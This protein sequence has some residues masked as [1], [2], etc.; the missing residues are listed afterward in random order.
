MFHTAT[1]LAADFAA[2]ALPAERWHQFSRQFASVSM[3]VRQRRVQADA[4]EMG[5]HLRLLYP[6]DPD[7]REGIRAMIAAAFEERVFF[8]KAARDPKWRPQIRLEGREYLEAAL[9]SGRGAVL[10]VVP[11][12]FATLV[13]KMAL[14]DAGFRTA[15][16]SRVGHGGGRSRL[17]ANLLNERQNVIEER[18][19]ER[20]VMPAEGRPTQ[21]LRELKRRLEANSIVTITGV[22][23]ADN[24]VELPFLGGR[25]RFATGAPRLAALN[26]APL[27]AAAALREGRSHRFRVKLKPLDLPQ[28]EMGRGRDQAGITAQTCA[29]AEVYEETVRHNPPL[30]RRGQSAVRVQASRGPDASSSG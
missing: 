1:F 26:R 15:H 4:C 10:W 24:P 9:Q 22:D 14:F 28:R 25:L 8:R 30:F 12:T 3:A 20:I 17:G 18:F 16:L 11:V 27:L 21:A 2:I 6:D 7:G 5:V 23:L 13:V 19:V 29:F